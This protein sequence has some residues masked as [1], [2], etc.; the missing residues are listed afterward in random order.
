MTRGQCSGTRNLAQHYRYLKNHVR[1]VIISPANRG[2]PETPME[3][4]RGFEQ[5]LQPSYQI[6][7]FDHLES[8]YLHCMNRQ[9]ERRCRPLL[10]V[11]FNI[12]PSST[13]TD[14]CWPSTETL[15]GTT[16][17]PVMRRISN[18][19]PLSKA[20]NCIIFH[21]TSWA[22]THCTNQQAFVLET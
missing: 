13:S 1:N 16:A 8:Q 10:H 21:C 11:L 9:P 14:N 12:V 4:V 15:F 5:C 22:P 7:D 3:V 18:I 19:S 2:D 6:L 20:H 17:C